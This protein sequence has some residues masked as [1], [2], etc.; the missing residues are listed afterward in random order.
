MEENAF[1]AVRAKESTGR[2]HSQRVGNL[3]RHATGTANER[4]EDGK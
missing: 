2:A 3:D 4:K 1:D